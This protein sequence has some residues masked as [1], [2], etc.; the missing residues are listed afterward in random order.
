MTTT[1]LLAHGARDTL[2]RQPGAEYDGISFADIL[3]RVRAPTAAEKT[4]ADFII[5]STYKG[6]DGRAH[7]VQRTRGAYRMLAIDIDTGHPSKADVVEAIHNTIGRCSLLL[8][9]SASAT[10]AEPKWR[11]LIPLK[12]PISGAEYED[13]HDESE[14]EQPAAGPGPQRRPAAA[15]SLRTQGRAG[16]TAPGGR[17]GLRDKRRARRRRLAPGARYFRRDPQ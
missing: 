9:S 12:Q 17:D 7:D 8:Y 10:K 15:R 6:H 16:T 1:F 3:A 14:G 5:P 2:I 4:D 11:V 13:A